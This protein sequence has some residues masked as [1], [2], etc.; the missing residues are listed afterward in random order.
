LDPSY[1]TEVNR[2]HRPLGLF[3]I[4][5]VAEMD[6]NRDGR[7]GSGAPGDGREVFEVHIFFNDARFHHN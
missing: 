6:G 2:F 1:I 3:Q 5:A 7:R 4:K